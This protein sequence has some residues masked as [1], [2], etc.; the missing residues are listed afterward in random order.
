MCTH[1][2]T[3]TGSAEATDAKELG[4]KTKIKN[5]PAKACL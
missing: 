3:W 4:L 2:W 1:T 5:P